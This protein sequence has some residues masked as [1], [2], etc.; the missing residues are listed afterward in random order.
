MHDISMFHGLIG[1]ET[2]NNIK[3]ELQKSEG[4]PNGI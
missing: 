2:N 3:H 4:L 1:I